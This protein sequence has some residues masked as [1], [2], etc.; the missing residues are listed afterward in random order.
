M[1]LTDEEIQDCINKAEAKYPG[2]CNKIWNESMWSIL[3][4]MW[5]VEYGKSMW[6]WAK[7]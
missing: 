1:S 5:Q 4:R 3:E 7:K 6:D 2:D